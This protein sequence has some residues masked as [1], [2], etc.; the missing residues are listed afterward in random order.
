MREFVKTEE[1]L[2]LCLDDLLPKILRHPIKGVVGIP[3]SGMM[4]ASAAATLLHVPAYS[5]DAG[6]LILLS[7]RSMWGGGRMANF[8]RESGCFLVIDDTVWEG[9]EM[10]RVKKIL[11]D[12]HPEE[13]FIFSAIYVPEDEMHRVNVYS[14]VFE[15]T[16]VPYLEWNFMS[17]SHIEKTI[18]DLDGLLCKDAPLSILNDEDR[19][20][21]FI[22]NVLP[23]AYVPRRLSCYS[24]L[25]GRSEKYREVTEKWLEDNGVL[26][27]E[28]LMHPN[29][30]GDVLTLCEL[31]DYKSELFSNCDARLL[32][33]SNCTIAKCINEKTE[34]TT[35]CL[36]EGKI[37]DVAYQRDGCREPTKGEI[38]RMKR[39][40]HPNRKHFLE[41]GLPECQCESA[42]YCSVFKETFG[43]NLHS[44]CQGSQKFRDN[45]VKIIN[46]KENDPDRKARMEASTLRNKNARAFD[47]AIEGL[48][49]E[50][51]SL[52]D[53]RDGSSEGLGDTVEKV[54]S[55]FGITK[56]LLENVAGIKGCRCDERKKWLNRIFPYS[57]KEE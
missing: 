42:G 49:E 9:R 36:P 38:L 23:S 12:H 2:R 7:G 1:L 55:K 17:N 52:K 21:E 48:K 41:N 18:L 4:L 56:K 44:R 6:G 26:Y 24:I 50:G 19:Y 10:R 25:T 22:K 11:K 45:Y 3:R 54:L 28:L 35:I 32:V 43:K 47:E 15:A 30:S 40:E 16:E 34:K 27:K 51:V 37:F 20:V 33:E 5:I 39:E 8:K 13:E 14:R 31:C 46:T 53:V 29:T 57:K